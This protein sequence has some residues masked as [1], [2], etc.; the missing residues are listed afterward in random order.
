MN[1]AGVLCH[2]ESNFRLEQRFF[3]PLASAQAHVLDG[4]MQFSS[5]VVLVVVKF[6]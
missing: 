3:M 2:L 4:F 1:R 5:N 6:K